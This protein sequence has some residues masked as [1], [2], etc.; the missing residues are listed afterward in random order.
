MVED[1]NFEELKGLVLLDA[2]A[3]V[4]DAAPRYAALYASHNSTPSQ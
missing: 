2:G 3:R 1:E 4:D